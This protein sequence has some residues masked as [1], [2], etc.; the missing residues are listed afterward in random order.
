MPLAFRPASPQEIALLSELA[1]ASKAHWGYSAEFMDA[2]REDLTLSAEV[3]REGL[4]VVG[5]R[6]GRVVGFYRLA[7]TPEGPYLKDLFVSPGVIGQGVGKLLWQHAAGHARSL[8][9]PFLLLDSEPHAEGFYRRVGA[10]KIGEV[11]SAV[12]SGRVLP[13]MRFELS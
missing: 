1:F 6:G 12:F 8:G 7:D 13:L 11:P 5:E 3:V 2:C 9:W 10:R 4:T